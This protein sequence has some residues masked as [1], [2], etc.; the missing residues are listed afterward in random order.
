M[1]IPLAIIIGHLLIR[2]LVPT[3]S[4]VGAEK[5]PYREKILKG[6]EEMSNQ[7]LIQ[8]I[9]YNLLS[10]KV[11]LKS[12]EIWNYMLSK[13]SAPSNLL[14]TETEMNKYK[15]WLTV[16]ED[17]RNKFLLL[18]QGYSASEIMGEAD[19]ACKGGENG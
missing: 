7:Y 11:S 3:E 5:T 9:D 10:I 18:Q 13:S 4:A 12:M 8:S 15:R 19:K 1:Y 16:F 17:W 2:H 14:F 6:K